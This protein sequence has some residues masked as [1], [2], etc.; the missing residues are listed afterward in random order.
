MTRR[1]ALVLGLLVA[2]CGGSEDGTP[3]ET[4]DGAT[5]A[6]TSTASDAFVASDGSPT[7]T[8]V[9]VADADPYGAYPA[10]PYGIKEGQILKGLEWEGY[11]NE[12]ADAL[13]TT[14]PYVS[15][16]LDKLRRTGKGYG[17]VHIS[18]WL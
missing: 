2:S 13:S 15:T 11:V 17:L 7:D 6:D 1:A 16:S 10:G 3:S 14:K 9:V 5:A 4:T 18:E 12:K 8:A